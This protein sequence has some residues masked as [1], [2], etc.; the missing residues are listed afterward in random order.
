MEIPGLGAVTEDE[1][2]SLTSVPIP[3]PVFGNALLPFAVDGYADDPAPE[4]FP[5]ITGPAEVWGH[6]SST[7][8]T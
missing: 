8:T 3:L 2:G 6:V 5:R 1:Y 4:D 7:A